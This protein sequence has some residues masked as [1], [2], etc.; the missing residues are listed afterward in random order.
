MIAGMTAI[1][2]F[3]MD[4]MCVLDLMKRVDVLLLWLD[5]RFY[6]RYDELQA[7]IDEHGE[8]LQASEIMYGVA[9]PT[10]RSA[11]YWRMV[12]VEALGKYEPEFVF[13]PDSD[14]TFGPGFE[15]DFARFQKSDYGMLMFTYDMPTKDGRKV[16]SYPRKPHCKVYRWQPGLQ[17]ATP[18]NRYATA[19]GTWLTETNARS[20]IQHYCFYTREYQKRKEKTIT[21][22]PWYKGYK[23]IEDKIRGKGVTKWRGG[24]GKYSGRP[25]GKG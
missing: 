19:D 7:L 1:H 24:R 5:P 13:Q 22:Y 20:K 12:S 11:K 25:K 15:R 17:V 21:E 8:H 23:A 9:H 16:Y 18:H 6:H 4:Q 14:E 10:V 3:P 2:D